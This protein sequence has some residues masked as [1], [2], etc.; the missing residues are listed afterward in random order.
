VIDAISGRS[1]CVIPRALVLVVVVSV[2]AG[3]GAAGHEASG[4]SWERLPAAPLSPR[5]PG[6]ALAIG[7]EALFIGGDDDPCPPSADCA[8]RTPGLRDGAA[9]DPA[10][11]HWKRI[12]DAPVAFTFADS[13]VVGDSAYLMT[14]GVFLRYQRAADRWTRLPAPRDAYRRELVAAGPR[15]VAYAQAGEGHPAP[16]L[17]FDPKRGRWAKLPGDPLPPSYARTMAWN[18]RELVLFTSESPPPP[19]SPGSRKP[20]LVLAAAFDPDRATWRRLADSEILG[21]GARWFA[22]HGRLILPALGSADGGEVNNWGRSYPNGGILDVAANRWLPLPNAPEGEDEFGAGVVA[23]GR[24]DF[25]AIRGWVLDAAAE[26]WLR[27]PQLDSPDAAVSRG[28]T[29]VGRDMVVFGGVRFGDAARG[30][31]LDEAWMWSVP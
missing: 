11:R 10:S 22:D 5:E 8:A 1:W 6:V 31:L 28:V 17:V 13:A 27:V 9:F 18:G 30:E 29:A 15:I 4:G 12:A 26:K 7:G 14:D 24:G 2:L 23:G 3:C 21:G 19:E 20:S 25:T 16:D